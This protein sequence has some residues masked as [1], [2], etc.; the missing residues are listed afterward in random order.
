MV[1][2]VRLYIDASYAVA[3]MAFVGIVCGF[4]FAG[5][6]G[7]TERSLQVALAMFALTGA[8]LATRLWRM[9][10]KAK[11]AVEPALPHA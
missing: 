8:V 6:T 9:T 11:R 4:V 7:D 3:W 5:F 2:T 1:S 10:R